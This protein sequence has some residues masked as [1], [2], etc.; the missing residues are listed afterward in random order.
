MPHRRNMRGMFLRTRLHMYLLW[1]TCVFAFLAIISG[2]L[3]DGGSNSSSSTTI[4]GVVATTTTVAT[5]PTTA[6]RTYV[7]QSGE[8]LFAIAMKFN[9]SAPALV[10][11][12]KIKDPDRVSAGTELLLPPSNGFVA[13]GASTTMAP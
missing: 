5:G 11:L 7:V 3:T 1:S 4:A 13:I 10:E 2:L 6:P 12:N 8:S 9:L